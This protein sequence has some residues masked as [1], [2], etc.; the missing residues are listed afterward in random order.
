MMTDGVSALAGFAIAA[1]A[2][3]V[4]GGGAAFEHLR[5]ARIPEFPQDRPA[6]VSPASAASEPAEQAVMALPPP[7]PIA[8]VPTAGDSDLDHG[9]LFRDFEQATRAAMARAWPA[10]RVIQPHHSFHRRPAPEL[11]EP[12]IAPE[13]VNPMGCPPSLG[14]VC[15][16]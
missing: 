2:I 1:G 11:L 5:P 6:I 12:E 3:I 10:H 14:S 16:R 4:I 7:P 9:R 15:W 8:K 13:P